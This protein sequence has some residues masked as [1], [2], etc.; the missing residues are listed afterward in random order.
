MDEFELIERFFTREYEDS[1]VVAGIGDDGA[2]LAP[3]PGQQLVTVV[4]TLVQGVH[5][6]V[7]ID[8]AD[9]GYR[10]VAVNLSDVAA[11]GAVPRWMTLALTL[12]SVDESWLAGFARGLFEAAAEHDVRL[13]GG[14]TTSGN[15]V[16]ATVQILAEVGEGKAMLRSGARPG[17]TI[18]VTGTLGDAAAGLE[19]LHIGRPNEFLSRRYLRPTARVACGQQIQGIATAAI[20]VS[21]GLYAD[22]NKL[23]Q[24]SGVGGAVNLDALPIS[25]QLAAS[26]G[27]D[28]RRRL[29]L[30]GGDDYELCFT[31]GGEIRAD[32]LDVLVTAIGTVTDASGIVCRADGKVVDYTDRGYRHFR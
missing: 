25:A 24:A 16:V 11:M 21:D 3:R 30:S 9:L 31:S 10:V 19:L 27:A 22:L 29:A 28:E 6:P 18:Y 23:L 1:G 4:D 32:G 26:F 15:A 8:A 13:V 12:Y 20:D 5:F 17:D 7:D 14:D 2:V